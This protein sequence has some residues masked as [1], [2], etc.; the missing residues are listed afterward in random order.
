MHEQTPH[1]P[2]V[3]TS[4]PGLLSL[5]HLITT[6]QS[7]DWIRSFVSEYKVSVLTLQVLLRSQHKIES[8]HVLSTFTTPG[9]LKPPQL[10]YEEQDAWTGSSLPKV[11]ELLLDTQ[12]QKSSNERIIQDLQSISRYC[13]KLKCLTFGMPSSM[14]SKD[15]ALSEVLHLD[16]KARLFPNLTCLHLFNM[17]IAAKGNNSI[18][19]RFDVSR[20]KRLELIHCDC[21]IPLL[22]DLTSFYTCGTGDLESL[23]ILLPTELQEPIVTIEAID[24]LLMVCSKLRSL[25]L[26]FLQ[27]GF[28]AKMS[29]LAHCQTLRALTIGTGNSDL[30]SHFPVADMKDLLG[31]C[32]ELRMLGVNMP[33]LRAQMDA[34][35]DMSINIYGEFADILV[36]A[37]LHYLIYCI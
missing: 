8:V 24:D 33:V 32:T 18:C 6:A 1:E 13:P 30:D 22:E 36:L 29:V 2:R 17:E 20:L 26:D 37:C 34:W 16:E 7:I 19:D 4:I 5:N 35:P 11:S 12:P 9:L 15:T 27:H 25:W 3:V 31:A 10:D 28:V 23:A 14:S 21:L